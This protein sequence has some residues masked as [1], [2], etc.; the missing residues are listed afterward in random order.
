MK[1]LDVVHLKQ[2]TGDLSGEL[3]L[4]AK[5]KQNTEDQP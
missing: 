3:R 2:H 4:G 5:E 1:K